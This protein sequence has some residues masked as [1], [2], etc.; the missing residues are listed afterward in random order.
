MTT[1]DPSASGSEAAGPVAPVEARGAGPVRLS[2]YLFAPVPD[3][4]APCVTFEGTSASRAELCRR[5]AAM[6]VALEEL[7]VGSGHLVGVHLENSPAAVITMNAVWM[8]GAVVAPFSPLLAERE[9]DGLVRKVEPAAVVGAVAAGE[10][11]RRLAGAGLSLLVDDAGDVRGGSGRASAAPPPD[12]DGAAVVLF[13]S[14][15]TGTPK[16]VVLRHDQILSG[17]ES[18]LEHVGGRGRHDGHVARRGAANVVAF[19]WFHSSGLLNVLLGLRNDREILL[20]RRFRVA[21]FLALVEDHAVPSVV[22]NPAMLQML[23]EADE[24]A[25]ERLASLRFVR[26]GSAPLSPSVAARFVA[27]FDIPVLNCYGQTETGGE[28]IGWTA[29]DVRRYGSSKLG[30]VGRP[31]PGVEIRIGTDEDSSAAPGEVGELCLRA[32]HI[33]REALGGG[34]EDRFTADGFLRTGDVGYVDEDG[35]VWLTGRVSDV[36]VCGG[37]KVFPEEVEEVLRGYPGVRDVMV[38]GMPDDRLGQVPHAFIVGVA[39]EEDLR[40]FLREHLAHYKVPREFH[41][42]EGVPRNALGKLVRSRAGGLAA[43]ADAG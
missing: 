38:A 42:V 7:G 35:F 9:L 13:T 15:T 37:F 12:R 23:T 24:A 25:P 33:R 5:V 39:V 10:R 21:D 17:L 26:T 43:A 31:H 30:S 28:V 36:V 2:D 34:A 1:R 19:P 27:K 29:A 14:G 4:D 41:F 6:T 16:P 3:P 8:L 18:V 32:R 40:S 11:I 20:M 22:L